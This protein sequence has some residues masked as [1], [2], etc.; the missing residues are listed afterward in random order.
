[1]NLHHPTTEQMWEVQTSDPLP[2]LSRPINIISTMLSQSK[3][4]ASGSA[5]D[6]LTRSTVAFIPCRSRHVKCDALKPRC[7]CDIDEKTCWWNRNED[8]SPRLVQSQLL[9]QLV[10]EKMQRLVVAVACMG[11]T[12][13][14]NGN[15]LSPF[16]SA[17]SSSFS[18]YAPSFALDRPRLVW[19]QCQS[20]KAPQDN[21]EKL[22]T[23]M[24]NNSIVHTLSY[25]QRSACFIYLKQKRCYW[26]TFAS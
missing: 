5:G 23:T 13:S 12:K 17:I 24:T 26:E 6:S 20:T 7:I 9:A 3:I 21:F 8:E 15:Q 22:L 4:Y 18:K 10:R 25:F 14:M 16:P 1:M 11:I 19:S 2:H